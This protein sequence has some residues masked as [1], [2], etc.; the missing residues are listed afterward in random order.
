MPPAPG[1]LQV[2]TDPP[3]P[4]LLLLIKPEPWFSN[5][6]RNLRDLFRDPDPLPLDSAPADFSPARITF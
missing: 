1:P 3:A 2:E 5:F 6:L 4:D